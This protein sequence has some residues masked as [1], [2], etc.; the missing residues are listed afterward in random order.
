MKIW[1]ISDTHSYHYLLDVP[2]VDVVIHSGDASNYKDIYKNE[3]EFM[4]FLHWFKNLPIKHKVYV[5][6]N[7]DSAIE[8]NIFDIKTKIKNSDIHYLEDSFVDIDGVKIY[9]SPYSPTFGSWSFMKN[10]AKLHKVWGRI[11]ENTDILVTHTP[12]KGILD[13]SFDREHNLEFCGC[14]ALMK[15]VLNLKLKAHLFGHI[16]N[17]KDIINAGTNK[18]S[19]LDTTFSN[20]SVVTDGKFGKLSSNGNV[21]T[22]KQ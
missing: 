4:D 8:K 10:R 13:L 18:L 1:H 5:A 9:G 16:H 20:G 11:P 12:P 15:R 6:G 14:S 17:N 22:I 7:H 21:I 19:I 3:V 2:K